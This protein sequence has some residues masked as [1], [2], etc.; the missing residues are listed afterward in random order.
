[1][2]G[3]S[4]TWWPYRSTVT[5]ESVVNLNDFGKSSTDQNYNYLK[6]GLTEAAVQGKLKN[7]IDV[8]KSINS[9]IK[10]VVGGPKIDFYRD[11]PADY[12]VV[13]FGETQLTDLLSDT[14]RLW[15][16]YIEHDKN[17]ENFDFR[18]SQTLYTDLDFI[19][20]KDILTI[21]FTRGCKFK[22]A[23]CSYPLIGRKN[24]VEE[25]LKHPDTIYRELMDNYNRWGTTKYWVADDTFNDSTEKLEIILSVIERLPFKPEF[26]AYT[27]LDVMQSNFRQVKL[28]KDIGL[29]N[30]WIGVDS[31]HPVASKV[32]GKGM[33]AERKKDLIYRIGEEWQGTVNIKVG[34]IV[35]LPGEDSNFVRETVD[36]FL[37]E[38]N[39]VNQLNLNPLRIL[40]QLPALAH[41]SRSDIDL[42]YQKYGYQIPDLTKFWEWTK[43]DGTDIKTFNDAANLCSE[44]T[45][46]IK[47][48][49][50]MP[51][52][53]NLTGIT[54]PKS[55]YFKPLITKLKDQQ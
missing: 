55:E 2:I 23:F 42:N 32:I 28:L 34:Y 39:P 17:A 49:S 10:I 1:M 48:R 18:C 16:T 47:K 7:W 29:V 9:K 14:K 21:E 26:R 19:N 54:D 25:S 37:E 27:R 40:P 43:E 30:T 12:F 35:G 53:F 20:S 31:I 51:E 50:S 38:T 45:E 11:I 52:T 46:K 6:V 5:K 3:F 13:G 36:W 22:C 8:A 33:S 4:T 15:P 24:V 41:T 44:L